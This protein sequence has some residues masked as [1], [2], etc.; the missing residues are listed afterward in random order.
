MPNHPSAWKCDTARRVYVVLS[1]PL[2]MAALLA[3]AAC[4]GIAAG[5]RLMWGVFA[6][7]WS[8]PQ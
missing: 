3:P 2:V 8:R 1:F 6:E 4:Y 7:V 5:F